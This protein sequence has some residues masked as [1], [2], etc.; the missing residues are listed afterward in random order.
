M[1]IYFEFKNSDPLCMSQ[2]GTVVFVTFV[3]KSFEFQLCIF[4]VFINAGTSQFFCILQAW[5]QKKKKKPKQLNLLFSGTQI[6]SLFSQHLQKS[7]RSGVVV[8]HK[9]Q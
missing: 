7:S 3:P 4:K 8:F 9:S 1:V 5:Q 2:V 6:L